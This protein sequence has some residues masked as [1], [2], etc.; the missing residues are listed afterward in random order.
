ME[1]DVN[2]ARIRRLLTEENPFLVGEVTDV[3][4][5]ERHCADQDGP[6]VLADFTSARK[7]ALAML[8]GLGVEWSRP[9]RHAIFG[10]TT[11]HELVGFIAGHDRAH[12]Q[13]VLKTMPA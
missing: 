13:Q 12:I 10:P 9:A 7:E 11:L 1:R 4:V 8:E 3:W 5:K 6:Q 2:L